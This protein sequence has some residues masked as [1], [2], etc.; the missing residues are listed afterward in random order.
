MGRHRFHDAVRDQ[1]RLLHQDHEDEER[2]EKEE[3]DCQGRLDESHHGRL[4]GP[5][6]T[7]PVET[8]RNLTEPL[9][10]RRALCDAVQCFGALGYSSASTNR[11]VWPAEPSGRSALL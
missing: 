3:P 9:A 5:N 6:L 4:P 7:K 8:R 10:T 11:N 1:Q 2:Y